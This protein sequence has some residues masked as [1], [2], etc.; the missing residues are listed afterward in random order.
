MYRKLT[1]LIVNLHP[2]YSQ[3]PLFRQT[4]YWP[5]DELAPNS[6]KMISALWIQ[7]PGRTG[8]RLKSIIL[9]EYT[10][11]AATKRGTQNINELHT[12]LS[13]VY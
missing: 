7:L 6:A 4:G 5:G 8:M 3:C 12:T 11:S 1:S 2:R 9:E 13:S 10:K